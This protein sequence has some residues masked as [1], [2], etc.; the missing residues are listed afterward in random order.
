MELFYGVK[1]KEGDDF[2]VNIRE[3]K[4][5]LRLQQNI[6]K[7]LKGEV[8][9]DSSE[10]EDTPGK[11]LEER[12]S[13][14][15]YQGSIVGCMVFSSEITDRKKYEASI[16][17][18]SY[19]DALTGLYNRRY[20]QEKIIS[21]DSEKNQPISVVICDI[22]GLKIMN[23]AF[24]HDAGDELLKEVSF[25][26]KQTFQ[27]KGFV[28]RTGGDEFAAILSNTTYEQA[29]FMADK[30][31]QSLEKKNIRGMIVS[32][33]F[34]IATKQQDEPIEVALRTAEE[35]MYKNKLFEISSHRN[36]SIK[37]I[38][39]T[40]YEKNPREHKHSKKSI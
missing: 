30:L 3:P 20:Y 22:N 28:C 12:F 5:R 32:V 31:K 13:P 17:Y 11:F 4:M 34:G 37:T 24:G 19:N 15:Y 6:Q 14:I 27:T 35:E 16:L 8:V 9:I 26:L 10:V 18:L 7:T 21:I 38:L 39:N 33:S 25:Q 2:L 1:I 40:L 29:S 36:E 23:D